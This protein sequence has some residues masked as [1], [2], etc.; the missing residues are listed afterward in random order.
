MA[1]QTLAGDRIGSI[2]YDHHPYPKC[3]SCLL[4]RILDGAETPA[5]DPSPV[6]LASCAGAAVDNT[7]KGQ[8]R[9][10]EEGRSMV[11][12][13]YPNPFAEF[14]KMGESSVLS[15]QMKTFAESFGKGFPLPLGS[16]A[17]DNPQLARSTQQFRELVDSC[18]KLSKEFT[19]NASSSK[20]DELTAE[21]LQRILDPR[22]W[23]NATGLV[24]DAVRR[25]T[26]AP[27]LSDLWQVEGK[28]LA[29]MQAW[30][31]VR[32]LSVEHSTLLLNGWGKA[33]AEFTSTLKANIDKSP[34]VSRREL[35]NQWVETANRHLME[36][37]AS[38]QYLET[39]RKLLK[40]S[41]DLRVAQRDLT[42]YY[43]EVLSLPTRT[44]VDDLAR[45]V[46]ELRREMRANK[47]DA[48]SH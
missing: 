16:F 18:L 31:E 23:L 17:A 8:R 10:G 32:S 1:E 11:G 3:N 2:H 29:L 24:D 28:Y 40:A 15:E 48:T 39:Q 9:T 38:P 47:R 45:M 36:V 22:E 35:V 26:E 27:K 14:W 19:P 34:T 41:T 13:E 42:E 25:L 30:G 37:Q 21:L 7:K 20:S 6:A 12:P 43:S 46:S 44:E 33:A 5:Y 4:N